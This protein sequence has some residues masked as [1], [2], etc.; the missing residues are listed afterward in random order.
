[1]YVSIQLICIDNDKV[2]FSHLQEDK[3]PSRKV[4]LPKDLTIQVIGV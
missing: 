1:M 3:T 2:T 4:I